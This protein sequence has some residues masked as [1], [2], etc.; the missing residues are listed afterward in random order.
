MRTAVKKDARRQE[1]LEQ[2]YPMIDE[3]GYENLTVR[4]ICSKLDI[5]T[6]TFYHYFP[7]K[8]DLLLAFFAG[9]DDFFEEDIL[10][11]F[12]GDEA[13]NMDRFIRAY[14][15]YCYHVGVGVYRCLNSAPAHDAKRNYLSESRP[16]SRILYDLLL[17]GFAS[18][19]FHSPLTPEQCSRTIMITLRGYGADWAKHNGEYELSETLEDCIKMVRLLLGCPVE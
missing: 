7:E 9:I 15:Q 11:T 18:G 4:G 14:G 1:L 10:P 16:I 19:Q 2:I 5:S 13:K 6:G 12:D 17:R 8:A 3:L